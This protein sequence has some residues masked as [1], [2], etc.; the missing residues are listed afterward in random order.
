MGAVQSGKTASMLGVAALSIDAGI[1]M[2]VILAGTRITLWRQTIERLLAQLDDSLDPSPPERSKARLLVPD[3]ILALDDNVVASPA[4]LYAMNGPRLRRATESKIPVVV[5]AMKNVDHL[6]AL[7]GIIR[8]RLI[9]IINEL[10]RPFHMLVLDD[11]SDDGSILDAKFEESLDPATQDLKQIPRSIV[12]LWEDRPHNGITRSVNLHATYI[13]YTAT[14]QANFLQADHNPL[15][16]KDFAISLRTPFDH[17]EVTPRSP[18]FREPHGLDAFYTGG[19]AFYVRLGHAICPPTSANPDKDLAD[20][21]RGYLVAGAIRLW[22]DPDRLDPVDARLE[23]FSGKTEA[24]ASCPK[25]HSMLFHPSP[26]I[27]DHFEGAATV[28]RVICGFDE[29]TSRRRIFSGDR[30]LPSEAIEELMDS[31]EGLWKQWLGRYR[32]SADSVRSA[33]ELQAP[34]RIPD[35][36]EWPE[37][38]SIIL[39]RLIP[40]VQIKIVNSDPRAD[41]RPQFEP[42]EVSPGQ[43]SAPADLATIFVSGNVMSR[44]LT[45]DGLTTTLFLRS[46]EDP[47]ADTQMQ[48]Q[49]WFGYR[50]AYLELCRVFLPKEQLE[51]FRC[52]QDTDEAL[53]LTVLEAMNVDPDC[54]P[55]PF[56]LQGPDFTATGKL[57]NVS[58]VP[59]CPGPYPFVRLINRG[60]REDPNIEVVSQIFVA[61]PSVDITVRDL[62]RGRILESPLS[63][64]EAADLLDRLRYQNHLP[65]IN[66]WEGRRWLDLQVKVGIQNDP[67]R[68]IP[69]FRPP[70]SPKGTTPDVRSGPYAISAYMRLWKACLTHRARGLV[71]TDDPLTR[72]SMVDLESKI[73]QQPFFYVGIRY[74][75][76]AE[77]HEGPLGELLFTVKMMKRAVVGSEVDGSWGSRNPVP[78]KGQYLGDQLFDYH[79]H[80]S[81]PPTAIAGE[82]RWRSPGSPGLILFHVIE[83]LDQPHPTVAVGV[84]LPLGGPDQFAAKKPLVTGVGS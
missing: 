78:G 61:A 12:D 43:W 6:R 31:E 18:T 26:A 44:G 63:L 67:D 45:L 79:F 46:S 80:K 5:V 54:A 41:D 1:D 14:P 73:A 68:I 7:G 11:E 27:T 9:P 58:N 70:T 38:R 52:Y 71:D 15:S 47:Y 17:G 2:V 62:L 69:F 23:Y 20:A 64:L 56:V 76:G 35:D 36:P 77:I 39:E 3:P 82:P 66:G 30:G 51:L 65:N 19:E 21:L 22:R 40:A 72:W 84:C 34:A 33:F 83:Q 60:D 13:G 32:S 74:G 8:D 24:F 4:Q 55:D 81:K 28:L 29:I 75:K 48:M 25:P 42:Q 49:R 50:G 10:D 37:I 16:P 57:T 53:R 59:L